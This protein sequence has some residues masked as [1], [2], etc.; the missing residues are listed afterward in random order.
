MR[1]KHNHLGQFAAGCPPFDKEGYQ[2]IWQEA[3]ATKPQ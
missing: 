1:A 2:T 3:L